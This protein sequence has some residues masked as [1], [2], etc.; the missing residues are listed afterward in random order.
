MNNVLA[1]SY[2]SAEDFAPLLTALTDNLG[3]V[4]PVGIGILVTVAAVKML[5]GLIK[6]WTRG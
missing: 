5:P 6:T 4:V 2:V 1:A 3:V